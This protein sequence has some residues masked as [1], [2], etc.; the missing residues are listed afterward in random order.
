MN[1]LLSTGAYRRILRGIDNIMVGLVAID[2]LTQMKPAPIVFIGATGGAST[3]Q[4]EKKADNKDE[5]KVKPGEQKK[6]NVVKKSTTSTSHN[7]AGTVAP[8]AA[9]PSFDI[10]AIAKYVVEIVKETLKTDDVR[11]HEAGLQ[12]IVHK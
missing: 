8:G 2:G 7:V 6:P 5:D 3:N 11:R 9:Q 4:E 1:G 12:P 10:A